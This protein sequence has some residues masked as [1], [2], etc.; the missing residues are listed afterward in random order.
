MVD[1]V[2]GCLLKQV[3]ISNSTCWIEREDQTVMALRL[4][5]LPSIGRYE[6][7]ESPLYRAF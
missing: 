5:R 7:A 1:R 2:S 6:P 4:F 3:Y